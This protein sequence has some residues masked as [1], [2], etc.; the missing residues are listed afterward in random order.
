MKK[1][2]LTAAVIVTGAIAAGVANQR[3]QEQEAD[4]QAWREVTDP[5]E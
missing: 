4:R 3:F 5:V 2:L 1:I